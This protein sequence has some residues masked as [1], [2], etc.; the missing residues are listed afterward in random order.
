[1]KRKT[2]LIMLC[3]FILSTIKVN[4]V[5]NPDLLRELLR[6]TEKP[7]SNADS[8]YK[9]IEALKSMGFYKNDYMDKQ[10]NI[11][12]AIIRFQSDCNLVVDGIPGKMFRSAINKRMLADKGYKYLDIV[13]AAPTHGK[14]ITINRTKRILT[15]YNYKT[16][17]KKYPVAIGKDTTATPQGKFKIVV[18][19]RNPMWTGGGFAEPVQ[20]GSPQ[21]PLGYRWIGLSLGKGYKYGIHGNNSP[22]S[23]GRDVSRGCIRMINSDVNELYEIVKKGTTVWIGDEE[24]LNKWGVMQKSFY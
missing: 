23:I 2:T 24:T 16:V 12:N 15:L 5:P 3:I 10:I 13:A 11:R 6:E 9:H 19:A 17:V 20:G 18:K 21:N 8:S 14:W 4:A 7:V 22:Y 1:M